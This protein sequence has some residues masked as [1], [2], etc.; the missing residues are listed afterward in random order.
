[1][2]SGGRGRETKGRE[3]ESGGVVWGGD[4]AERERGDWAAYNCGLKRRIG[5][6]ASRCRLASRSGPGL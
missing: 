3:G 2:E 5:D 6:G 1:M 4:D